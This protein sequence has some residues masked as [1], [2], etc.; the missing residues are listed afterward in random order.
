MC[1]SKWH[2]AL[3]TDKPKRVARLVR[4]LINPEQKIQQSFFWKKSGEI[5][6]LL[7]SP[8]ERNVISER[9]LNLNTVD[10]SGVGFNLT[11][12][13]LKKAQMQSLLTYASNRSILTGLQ[14]LSAYDFL[15][16]PGYDFT[17]SKSLLFTN[18]KPIDKKPF[19]A[20]VTQHHL[21][22]I[23]RMRLRVHLEC[24]SS[25]KTFSLHQFTDKAFGADTS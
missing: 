7:S 16:F 13:I 2:P 20:N 22:R 18:F 9:C 8:F 12:A 6:F 21:S 14:S 1:K 15:P 17:L 19:F 10:Y 3:F 4:N 5:F 24:R 23:S 11:S 25:I